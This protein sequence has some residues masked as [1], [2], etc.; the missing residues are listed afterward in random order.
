MDNYLKNDII[1]QEIGVGS[2]GIVYED[3]G[4]SK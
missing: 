1:K 3:G 2:K 4:Q